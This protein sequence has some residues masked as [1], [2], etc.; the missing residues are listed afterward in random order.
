VKA[1]S[2]ADEGRGALS[3]RIA[4]NKLTGDT[5]GEITPLDYSKTMFNFDF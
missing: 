1:L 2:L 3:E 5:P 4:F